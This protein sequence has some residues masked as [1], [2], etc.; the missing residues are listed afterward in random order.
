[1]KVVTIRNIIY[2]CIF[3]YSIQTYFCDTIIMILP[4]A[5]RLGYANNFQTPKVSRPACCAL[6]FI[7]ILYL[8]WESA[9]YQTK[10]CS[11]TECI[12]RYSIK[13]H[14]GI[15]YIHWILRIA[16]IVAPCRCIVQVYKLYKYITIF[17]AAIL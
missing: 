6:Q 4:C 9:E 3:F 11:K 5:E 1:M 16:R 10:K 12:W 8:Q 17:G 14:Q 7:N 15:V 2:L 13:E